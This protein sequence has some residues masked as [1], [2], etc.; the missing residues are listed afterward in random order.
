MF[1]SI[2]LCL[3]TQMDLTVTNQEFEIRATS[4][5]LSKQKSPVT[6]STLLFALFT[7]VKFDKLLNLCQLKAQYL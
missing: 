1:L 6:I 7:Q 5:R 4:M 3:K 2:K